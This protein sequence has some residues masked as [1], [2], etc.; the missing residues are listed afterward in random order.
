M[1]RNGKIK[2]TGNK[3]A[4]DLTFK[5]I[6]RKVG[7]GGKSWL[8]IETEEGKTLNYFPVARYGRYIKFED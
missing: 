5:S 1:A 3:E 7:R 8:R 6:E 2:F 4:L